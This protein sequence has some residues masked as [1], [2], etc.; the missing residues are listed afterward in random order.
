[1]VALALCALAFAAASNCALPALAGAQSPSEGVTEEPTP[2]PTPTEVEHWDS[3]HHLLRQEHAEQSDRDAEL[4]SALSSLSGQVSQLQ[5]SWDASQESSEPAQITCSS[6]SG[7]GGSGPSG[8]WSSDRERVDWQPPQSFSD[9]YCEVHDG[10]TV[11]L[12]AQL[13]TELLL[14][15]GLALMV[16]FATLFATWRSRP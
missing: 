1:V 4:A 9:S 15:G 3:K 16:L 8:P 5:S 7:S 11:A 14:I 2:T 13:R 10:R 12:L 6:P